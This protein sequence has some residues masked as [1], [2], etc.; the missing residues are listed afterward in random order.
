MAKIALVTGA[1]VRVGRAIAQSLAED[2]FQ[3]ALHHN[4]SAA[5]A[6]DLAR[7]IRHLGGTAEPFQAD[8]SDPSAARRLIRA[9]EARFGPRLDL[10][11]NS[12]SI[13][14]PSRVDEGTD[15]DWEQILAINLRAPFQLVREAATLLRAAKGTVVNIVDLSAFQAWKRFGIHAVSK[16]SLLKLTQVQARTYA[17]HV[18]VNA[19]AP[20]N[21]LPPEDDTQEEIEASRQRI[22][23]GRI[24]APEDVVRAVRYLVDAPYVTGEVMVVDGGRLLDP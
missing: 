17:P 6:E 15:D 19:V 22:P 2:G 16:A 4:R 14:R 1:A 20:G 10:L 12:A 8:L 24:G 13:Y 21:V 23:L 9:V 3:M 5:P 7:E 11:V 18:R